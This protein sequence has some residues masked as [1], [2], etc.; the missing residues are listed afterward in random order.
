M[1]LFVAVRLQAS[2]WNCH[3]IVHASSQSATYDTYLAIAVNTSESDVSN[4][5]VFRAQS[6]RLMEVNEEFVRE[7][8]SRSRLPGKSTIVLVKNAS[9]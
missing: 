3:S 6:N 9:S 5:F 7:D 2:P 1:N 8:H 4:V